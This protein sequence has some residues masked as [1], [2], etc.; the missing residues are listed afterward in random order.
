MSRERE[1]RKQLIRMLIWLWAT[2]ALSLL[3]CI[4]F[5][6]MQMGGELVQYSLSRGYTSIPPHALATQNTVMLHTNV[7]SFTFSFAAGEFTS[8]LQLKLEHPLLEASNP[9]A[10]MVPIFDASNESEKSVPDRSEYSVSVPAGPLYSR[11]IIEAESH[12]HSKPTQYV[13]HLLR[14]GEAVTLSLN[15]SINPVHF[16]NVSE[17]VVFQEKRRW[18]HQVKN[19]RWF[20]PDLDPDASSSFRVEYLPTIFAPIISYDSAP[21]LTTWED[22]SL[23]APSCQCEPEAMGFGNSC[24]SENWITLENRICIFQRRTKGE[25]LL[26]DNAARVSSNISRFAAWLSDVKVSGKS[27][28]IRLSEATEQ[29]LNLQEVVSNAGARRLVNIFET[30]IRTSLLFT[31][32]SQLVVTPAED[33]T[34]AEMLV[35]PFQIVSHPPPIHLSLLRDHGFLLPDVVEGEEQ[36]EVAACGLKDLAGVNGSVLDARFKVQVNVV[37][38]GLSCD[39]ISTVMEKRFKAIR[40]PESSCGQYCSLYRPWTTG[41]Y[42]VSATLSMASCLHKAIDL[43]NA[44][45]FR[46]LLRIANAHGAMSMIDSCGTLQRAVK[47][48]RISMVKEMLNSTQVNPNGGPRSTENPL[49]AAASE[50][51]IAAMELLIEK[52]ATL[53]WDSSRGTALLAAGWNCQAEAVTFLLDKGSDPNHFVKLEKVR[54]GAQCQ[55]NLFENST[56][57]PL[58]VDLSKR[59]VC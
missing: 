45:A 31:Q 46:R 15:A 24:L 20:V 32:A 7:D 50:G 53:D 4:V 48:N 28:R 11:L 5:D 39:G 13:I 27:A 52:N 47:S 26:E 8:R 38:A 51:N 17:K 22:M 56:L 2:S 25:F 1:F 33:M 16:E 55:V 10:N 23:F 42:D 30:S 58:K 40:T 57:K 18:L 54:F 59:A 3:M 19:P 44:R 37:S 29:T 49:Q 12:L 9:V 35:V 6:G 43:D 14:L 36:S 21:K 34:D 41:P